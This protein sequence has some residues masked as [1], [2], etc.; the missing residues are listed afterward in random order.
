[1]AQTLEGQDSRLQVLPPGASAMLAC[2]CLA[3]WGSGPGSSQA[4]AL[5][6]FLLPG[7]QMT[8]KVPP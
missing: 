6:A 8:L 1:M 5:E 4:G 2:L 7:P 3:Y